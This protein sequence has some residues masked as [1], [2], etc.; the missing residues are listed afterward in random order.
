[1]PF[2]SCR[3]SAGPQA[4]WLRQGK[5]SRQRLDRLCPSRVWRRGAGPK[6]PMPG[7]GHRA[8][9]AAARSAGP[10]QRGAQSRDR[11]TAK[12]SDAPGMPAT[13]LLPDRS[14]RGRSSAARSRCGPQW[15]AR[16]GP[17]PERPQARWAQARWGAWCPAT[18]SAR[19][20]RRHDADRQHACR[21]PL[22]VFVSASLPVSVSVSVSVALAG[23]PAPS[24]ASRA[25]H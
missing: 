2:D 22:C 11:D 15:L 4:T 10:G 23:P 21:K 17:R 20:P 9:V 1:M 6:Q 12:D 25:R 3:R 14:A 16:H 7:A 13:A 24:L 8:R 19:P 5:A 18:D